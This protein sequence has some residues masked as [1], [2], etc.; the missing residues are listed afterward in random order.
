MIS[1]IFVIRYILPWPLSAI[2]VTCIMHNTW[3]HARAHLML[4]ETL[5]RLGRKVEAEA[6][7]EV[8]LELD[9]SLSGKLKT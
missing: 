6:E 2:S 9:P 7:L 5:T 8:A 3:Q 4:A 1:S